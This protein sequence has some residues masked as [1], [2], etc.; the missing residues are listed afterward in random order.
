M[1]ET[2]SV[3]V[4]EPR[5]ADLGHG[6][7]VRRILPHID[8]R[9]VGPYVFLDHAGPVVIDR[10]TARQ[11]DVRPHP[12]IGL[13]TVSYLLSG[14]ITHRDSLG[15]E[16][17]IIPGDV[18]W[19]TAGRGITHSERF[20]DDAAFTA[21]G[22]ELLQSWVAL[23][24]SD[25]EIEPAFEHVPVARLPEVERDGAWLRVIAGEAF[26]LRSP[27]RTRS[28]LFQAHLRLA[29]GARVE[30][31]AE[32]RE[33]AVYLIRGRVMIDGTALATGR[34][35][36]FAPGSVPVC[37]AE[38]AEAAELMAFGGEP[39]GPRHV[40][41]NFVSSRRERIEQAKVDWRE[42]RFALP[43]TDNDS[44]IPLPEERR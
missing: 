40:W 9:A 30:L 19:M 15:V 23:P 8:A 3:R 29:P 12:H 25:E 22:V 11:A 32:Q 13:A 33:R 5:S 24:E 26:G 44:F 17:S 37:T 34:T 14:A 43:P 31:P 4:I 6:L 18:N 2:P 28:T 1:P 10:A 38:G 21:P 20:E 35:M 42:G 36:V 16:Q 39:L 41:W 7:K 27:V